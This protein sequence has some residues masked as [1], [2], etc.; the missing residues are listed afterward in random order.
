MRIMMNNTIQK[1]VDYKVFTKIVQSEP[2]VVIDELRDDGDIVFS[3]SMADL[4][5]KQDSISGNVV[6][7]TDFFNNFVGEYVVRKNIDQFAEILFRI[8]PRAYEAVVCSNEHT[9]FGMVVSK[10]VIRFSMHVSLVQKILTEDF[11]KTI[12][13]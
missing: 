7:D 12:E 2:K 5:L 10:D 4:G 3:V 11:R 13:T 1:S 9:D 8:D 6:T